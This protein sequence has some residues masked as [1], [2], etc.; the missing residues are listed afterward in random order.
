LAFQLRQIDVLSSLN[1]ELEC[2]REIHLKSD[3]LGDAIGLAL[4]YCLE[5]VVFTLFLF[6]R[7]ILVVMT[8]EVWAKSLDLREDGIFFAEKSGSCFP[9]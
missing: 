6:L 2:G 5:N 7:G 8:R 4:L 1:L 3:D 9:K